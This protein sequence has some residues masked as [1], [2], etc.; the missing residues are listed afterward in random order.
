MDIFS[1][2]VDGKKM[3][4]FCGTYCLEK[5]LEAMQISLTDLHQE[6]NSKF[7]PTIRHFI[8]FAAKD[9]Q[10]LKTERGQAIDFPYEP[11]DVYSWIDAWGVN[12]KEVGGFT[13]RLYKSLLGDSTIQEPEKKSPIVKAKKT[14]KK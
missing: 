6:L 7:I 4:F 2:E 1:Y 3:D 8:Y 10:R 13:I 12:G 5:T 11:D 14:V 9:A